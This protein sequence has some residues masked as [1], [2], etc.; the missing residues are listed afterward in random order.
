M[1]AAVNPRKLHYGWIIVA[2]GAVV[3]FSCLGLARF[4][5]GMLLPAM[6]AGLSLS[7]D[8]MGFIGTGNF[9][10]YLA[11][12]VL[13][14]LLLRRFKPRPTITAGLLLIALC[15]F[16]ISRA[17]NLI[18]ICMLYGIVGLGSGFA[19][20]PMMALVSYWF[21]SE[22]RGRAAGLAIAGNGC[23]II[24]SGFFI[25]FLNRIH[26]AD[27][28]RDS[29][30]WLG[31]LTLAAAACAALALR[32]NPAELGLEP[33]GRSAPVT[34]DLFRTRRRRGEGR[35]L[36]CLG[37]LYMI[38]G[39][40]FMVYG[41][42]I[43]ST[44][45]REYGLD[46]QTAGLYWSWVGFFSLFSGVSFGALSDVIGRKLGL[47][48]VFAVQTAAY[49]LV[50]LKLGTVALLASIVLYGLAVFAIPAIMAAAM[51]DYLGLSRAAS[52]FATVTIFFAVGQAVGPS[53]AGLIA[54]AMGSFTPAYVAAGALTGIAAILAACLPAPAG[55]L[56]RR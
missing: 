27:G 12:V 38:F 20:I 54:R 46:E 25:P 53:A 31:L 8:R 21:H 23:A 34:E 18:T 32:N 5:Y 47:A 36:V 30:L 41:T 28:W 45:V 39:V 52:A 1:T 24:F 3:L 22:Q 11:S 33:V 9:I 43:V 35:I 14:P 56:R 19:N 16:G 37:L 17:E 2:T 26:G 29:W 42:F 13:S 49:L 51:G 15:M 55:I 10:G 4:T 40:T 50:G 48:L 44:M 7:P 6:Q